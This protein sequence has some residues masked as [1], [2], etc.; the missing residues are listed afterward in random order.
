MVGRRNDYACRAPIEQLCAQRNSER[1]LSNLPAR[2]VVCYNVPMKKKFV[3]ITILSLALIT[4]AVPAA[5]WGAFAL[6][7]DLLTEEPQ[8]EEQL[9]EE[10]QAN[11]D[12]QEEYDPTQPIIPEQPEESKPAVN[13]E[14]QNLNEAPSVPPGNAGQATEITR[15][16]ETTEPTHS[17][18]PTTTV[19]T[20]VAPKPA[21][22]VKTSLKSVKTKYRQA[23]TK[24]IQN[25]ITVT[26]AYGRTVKLYF[27]Y[28]RSCED[29]LRRVITA[30]AFRPEAGDPVSHEAEM[31]TVTVLPATRGSE[32]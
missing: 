30:L 32:P 31:G 24:P 18:M 4:A 20:T 10:P 23:Y 26:P 22:T 11:C 29:D 7:N 17:S 8:T 28:P 5:P 3:I 1:L 2:Q 27:S 12:L 19:T 16:A 21:P 15:Q 13:A 25:T 14:M 6:E 9:M